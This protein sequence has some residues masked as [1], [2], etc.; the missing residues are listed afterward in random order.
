MNIEAQ[1]A[2]VKQPI[3]SSAT[4]PPR[5]YTSSDWLKK[6]QEI[7]FGR[8]WVSVGRRDRWKKPGDYICIDLAG[9][10]I[11]VTMDDVGELHAL[12]NTCSH[13]GM[14]LKTGEG[15]CRQLVCPFHAWTYSLDGELVSAPRMEN[16]AQSEVGFQQSEY[17]L[18][19]IRLEQADGFVFVCFD[20]EQSSLQDWL[21]DFE[22]VHSP[23][24]LSELA[25]AR[26]NK[27]DVNCNWKTFIEVFNEYYH[28]PFVHPNSLDGL[29]HE[30]DESDAVIGEFATQFGITRGTA[31][32]MEQAQDHALP[33]ISTLK[34]RD[35]QGTRY[36]WAYPNM[37]FAACSDSLWM[38]EVYP[39]TADCCH[40]VQTICFPGASITLADFEQKA[41]RYYDR[42]DEAIAEDLPFLEAQQ[43]GLNSPLAKQG[44]FSALEPC[45]GHFA[46]WYANQM[47]G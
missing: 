25:T 26:V 12:A 42:I 18:A 46:C 40:V 37:T 6:E 3:S 38:Y 23:W 31:A 33:T 30:P 36:T 8:S 15:N 24:S 44:R 45:V 20:P 16:C 19:T 2:K 34:E 9:V 14:K 32:L 27:F 29:Y 4:L 10:P 47:G 21:A 17:G 11:V 13:R 7:I 22:D 35:Q 28:L 39:L 41:Q 43:Q 1:L 5:C